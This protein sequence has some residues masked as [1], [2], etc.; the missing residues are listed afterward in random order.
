MTYQIKLGPM[1]WDCTEKRFRSL[2]RWDCDGSQI[3]PEDLTEQV[4]LAEAASEN[5]YGWK[6]KITEEKHDEEE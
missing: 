5:F 2:E 4:M 6:I 1:L 3:A